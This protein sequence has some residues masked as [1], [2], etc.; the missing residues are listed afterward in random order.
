MQGLFFSVLRAMGWGVVLPMVAYPVFAILT[1]WPLFGP[2]FGWTRLFGWILEAG[3]FP[4]MAT[5]LVYEW[6]LRDRRLGV[7]VP[8]ILAVAFAFAYTWYRYLGVDN[9][10]WNYLTFAL[11]A[12]TVFSVSILPLIDRRARE[13]WEAYRQER[14]NQKTRYAS[15]D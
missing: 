11:A 9:L 4:S 14:A 8:A 3:F 1:F 12:A 7:A 6:A 15:F 13:S 5:A 10:G 2:L